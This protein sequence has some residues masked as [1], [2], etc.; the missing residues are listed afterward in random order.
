[1]ST[2]TLPPV[3]LRRPVARRHVSRV[4]VVVPDSADGADGTGEAGV[5]EWAA[6]WCDRAGWELRRH[7]EAGPFAAAAAARLD[8]RVLVLRPVAPPASSP[9]PLPEGRP[10]GTEHERPVEMEAAT[11]SPRVVAAVRSLPDDAPVVSDAAACA[12]RMGGRLRVVHAVPRSFAERS[13]GLAGAVTHGQRLLKAAAGRATAQE[14]GLHVDCELL[15]MRPYE[16]VGEALHADL[17]V[18]GGARTDRT[19]G[20]PGSG[21][22]LVAHSALHHAPCPVLLTPR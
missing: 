17:L 7:T 6:R 14:P 21:P 20:E 19:A 2:R 12:A 13:V 10:R 5:P 15:R 1:M 11:P 18:V 9:S 8:A 22:G 3:A 4:L 16:L